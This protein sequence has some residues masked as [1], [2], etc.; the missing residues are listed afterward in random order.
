MAFIEQA[1]RLVSQ[2][3]PA[4][5]AQLLQTIARDLVQ[6]SR[7]EWNADRIVRTPGGAGGDACV[8]DSRV[9]VWTLV[10]LKKLGRLEDDLL[11]DFPG[12]NRADLDAAW[13]YYR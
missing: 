10:Q 1:E 2:L 13:S 3:S 5:K 6:F 7:T 11:K 8:R 4:E 9:A 12:L